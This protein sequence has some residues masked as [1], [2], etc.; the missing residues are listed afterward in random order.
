MP[1]TDRERR[2]VR[3]GIAY[4][5]ASFVWWGVSPVYWKAMPGVPPFEL[6][7]NRIVWSLLLLVLLLAVRR[8]GEEVR[9]LLGNRRA[10]L[11]LVVTTALI[12]TNWFTYIWAM[13]AGRVLEAS[14]GYYINPL[15]NVLLGIVFLGERLRRA[16]G[17]A[18]ALAAV[19]VAVLTVQN[20]RVPW[21][22]LALAATFGF[23]GLLRKTVQAGPAVGLAV[24]TALL[25]PWMFA[26]LWHHASQGEAVFPDAG[27]GLQ[28]LVATSGLIT[29][30]PLVWFTTG[31]RRLPLS[32]LGLLQYISP[33]GQ[34]LLAVLVYGET[35]STA[36]LAAFASIWCGLAIF[37]WDL[38]RSL[39]S[40]APRTATR[41]P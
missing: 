22:A 20:G 31:A 12:A 32:T 7:A 14:L 41:G 15:F 2:H 9:L 40:P 16:Q 13:G 38:R 5:T 18:V 37:T 10:L 29:V 3:S 30:A 24:E 28:V 23:Y 11:T 17:W 19:G 27:L 4:A 34:F 33:T 35:F 36:H 25:A 8:R 39:R 21:V 1:E 26:W 6:L